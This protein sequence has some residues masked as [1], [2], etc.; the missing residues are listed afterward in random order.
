MDKEKGMKLDGYTKHIIT[1]GILVVT[2]VTLIVEPETGRNLAMATVT[3]F[4]AILRS[5]E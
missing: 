1:A 5:G 4:F 2:L 3:G